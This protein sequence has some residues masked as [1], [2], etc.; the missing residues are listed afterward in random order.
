[1]M[2]LLFFS[3]AFAG[4]L[5]S[6]FATLAAHA[7]L[8]VDYEITTTHH[9]ASS[10]TG[11][12]ATGGPLI[13]SIHGGTLEEGTSTLAAAVAA[14]GGFAHYDF[15]TLPPWP[16][17]AELHITSNNYDEPQARALATIQGPCLSF[18]G[19]RA[20]PPQDPSYENACVG[21]ANP[22]LRQAVAQ[23]LRVVLPTAVDVE[24]PC[25]LFPATAPENIVN[26]CRGQGVQLELTVALRQRLLGDAGLRRQLAAALAQALRGTCAAALRLK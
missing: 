19:Y 15:R 16:R 12:T 25:G 21:G 14:A 5:Y 8:G 11:G 26:R 1:M 13:L 18:H 3:S 17:A 6:D 2:L 4:D 24:E 23:A 7:T 9:G 10:T 22:T 20:R